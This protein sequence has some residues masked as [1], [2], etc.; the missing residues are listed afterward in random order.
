MPATGF[1]LEKPRPSHKSNNGF[2]LFR[3]DPTVEQRRVAN[4]HEFERLVSKDKE[5]QFRKRDLPIEDAF[6]NKVVSELDPGGNGD[7][8]A[9]FLKINGEMRRRNNQTLADLRLKTEEKFLWSG[10]FLRMNAKAE[11]TRVAA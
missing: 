11:S 7:L 8:L 6:L 2:A 1:A 4:A 10:A 3:S 5:L 9:R